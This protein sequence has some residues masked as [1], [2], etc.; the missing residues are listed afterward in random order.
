MTVD[1][2]EVVSLLRKG[3]K[4]GVMIYL[5]HGGDPN[6]R[7]HLGWTL[8]HLACVEVSDRS[9]SV[10]FSCTVN[11]CTTDMCTPLHRASAQGYSAVV[12]LLLKK[13][14]YV[15]AQDKAGNTPLHEAARGL[16]TAVVK[17]LIEKKADVTKTNH[18]NQVFLQLVGQQVMPV[19]ESGDCDTLVQ[20]LDWG[21]S[22]DIKGN[23]HWSALHHASARG[24]LNIVSILL[25]RGANVNA[26]D[27]N[28]TTPLHTAAFHGHLRIAELLID[29]G[30]NLNASDQRGNTPLHSAIEGCHPGVINLMLDRGCDT[31]IPNKEGQIFTHLVNEFLVTAVHAVNVGHVASLLKG[32]AD[33]DSRDSFGFPVLCHAAF[34][35]DVL[36]AD[37][38]LEAGANPNLADAGGKTPLHHAAYW[39]HLFVP[40]PYGKGRLLN[41]QDKNGCT[42]LHEA[43]REG[44]EDAITILTGRGAKLDATD[45]EGNTPLHAAARWGQTTAVELLI[46]KGASDVIKNKSGLLYSDLALIRAVRTEERSQVMAGLAWGGDPNS[47]DARRQT[48]LHH[49]VYKGAQE[50]CVLLLECGADVNAVDAH[51]R[52]PLLLAAYRGNHQIMQ[53]LL[54][55]GSDINAQDWTGQTPLHWA[56]SEGSVDTVHLLLER[57]AVTSV[58]NKDGLLYTDLLLKHLYLAVRHNDADKVVGLVRAGADQFAEVEGTGLNPREE[59]KRQGLYDILRQMAA[60]A[61]K[62]PQHEDD[63][64]LALEDVYRLFEDGYI[65]EDADRS[66]SACGRSE[67]EEDEEEDQEEDEDAYWKM[68][69]AY[70]VLTVEEAFKDEDDWLEA[71][72]EKPK[73]ISAKELFEEDQAAFWETWEEKPKVIS[74]KE[75]FKEDTNWWEDDD[76][77]NHDRRGEDEDKP[78]YISAKEFFRDDECWWRDALE[79]LQESQV[80]D[81]ELFAGGEEKKPKIMT[82]KDFFKDEEKPW[83]ETEEEEHKKVISAKEFFK[84]DEKPWWET[85]EFIQQEKPSGFL[86]GLKKSS[87]F[88]HFSNSHFVGSE[89]ESEILEGREEEEQEEEKED[90]YSASESSDDETELSSRTDDFEDANDSLLS[91]SST[92]YSASEG[93]RLPASVVFRDTPWW[94]TDDQQDENSPKASESNA[95]D[96]SQEKLWLD[97][98]S[99]AS[100]ATETLDMDTSEI[101]EVATAT[102]FYRRASESSQLEVVSSICVE[103]KRSDVDRMRIEIDTDQ[104]TIATDRE[105]ESEKRENDEDSN[106]EEEEEEK[107][108]TDEKENDRKKNVSYEEDDKGIVEDYNSE[109]EALKSEDEIED[110]SDEELVEEDENEYDSDEEGN[111]RNPS[112]TMNSAV[113][114][115][116]PDIKRD[117][118]SAVQENIRKNITPLVEIEMYDKDNDTLNSRPGD[119]KEKNEESVGI[120]SPTFD[121]LA[122]SVSKADSLEKDGTNLDVGTTNTDSLLDRNQLSVDAYYMEG[123]LQ[124]S[125]S[126]TSGYESSLSLSE[127]RTSHLTATCNVRV[128]SECGESSSEKQSEIESNENSKQEMITVE[129]VSPEGKDRYEPVTEVRT[130]TAENDRTHVDDVDEPRNVLPEREDTCNPVTKTMTE[131]GKD[132]AICVD[133]LQHVLPETED[134]YEPMTEVRNKAVEDDATRVN[135]ADNPDNIAEINEEDAEEINRTQ[136]K[137]EDV[138]RVVIQMKLCTDDMMKN[139]NEVKEENEPKTYNKVSEGERKDSEMEN[140]IHKNDTYVKPVKLQP[141]V[142]VTLTQ[143]YTASVKESL[144][145]KI[146]VNKMDACLAKVDAS[147]AWVDARL[148]KDSSSRMQQGENKKAEDVRTYAA[149]LAQGARTTPKYCGAAKTTKPHG[150]S[151]DSA[152]RAKTKSEDKDSVFLMKVH[153]HVPE[154]SSEVWPAEEGA[155][156]SQDG[157][158]LHNIAPANGKLTGGTFLGVVNNGSSD[159]K[160]SSKYISRLSE[161]IDLEDKDLNTCSIKPTEQILTAKPNIETESVAEERSIK[162]SDVTTSKEIAEDIQPKTKE[163]YTHSRKEIYSRRVLEEKTGNGNIKTL[164]RGDVNDD[165]CKLQDTLLNKVGPSNNRNEDMCSTHVDVTSQQDQRSK[166]NEDTCGT[167]VT[168]SQDHLSKEN[169]DTSGTQVDTASQQDQHSIENVDVCSTHIDTTSQQYQRSRENEDTCGTHVTTSQRN[170]CNKENEDTVSTNV[171]TASQDQNSSNMPVNSA[172]QEDHSL[173][174]ERESNHRVNDNGKTD[175]NLTNEKEKELSRESSVERSSAPSAS[176]AKLLS[177]QKTLWRC[178]T[179]EAMSLSDY[180]NLAFLISKSASSPACWPTMTTHK[181]SLSIESLD[182]ATDEVSSKATTGQ[183]HHLLEETLFNSTAGKKREPSEETS[184]KSTTGQKLGSPEDTSS[185]GGTRHKHGPSEEP[186]SRSTQQYAGHSVETSVKGAGGQNYDSTSEEPWNQFSKSN[187]MK[188]TRPDLMN[189]SSSRCHI[190]GYANERKDYVEEVSSS[191]CRVHKASTNSHD[192]GES[193]TETSSYRDNIINEIPQTSVACEA[194]SMSPPA[195]VETQACPNHSETSTAQHPF[196]VPPRRRERKLQYQTVDDKD[197]GHRPDSKSNELKSPTNTALLYDS[198]EKEAGKIAAASQVAPEARHVSAI[199]SKEFKREKDKTKEVSIEWSGFFSLTSAILLLQNLAFIYFILIPLIKLI[200]SF[201]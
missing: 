66:S 121:L 171:D 196:L 142:G 123:N 128:D 108:A 195:P 69:N 132:D 111:E 82:A 86:S 77:E 42:P 156:A 97:D 172:S 99:E 49:A 151:E 112:G 119:G 134:G 57:G 93:E 120:L 106:G 163:R 192:L 104:D 169:E 127:S 114:A 4:I 139:V 113:S 17:M 85:E 194:S 164:K 162:E 197:D 29:A 129:N 32:H 180:D 28:R 41:A 92:M 145:D 21:L 80:S 79:D 12:E 181:L 35:G 53:L 159:S 54:D 8:L 84:D 165:M 1:T 141:S 71:W 2:S 52:T 34:K 198:D 124:K 150:R 45:E 188:E 91:D 87:D 36:I 102:E 166:E 51:G 72:M 76:E 15:N 95:M 11:S 157:T 168:A 190:D 78:K 160:K 24:H 191:R 135:K 18:K 98:L 90:K 199:T 73:V 201:L 158:S 101:S 75:L 74:A 58:R 152:V 177:S 116:L 25:E 16:H 140:R 107:E 178:S 63:K 126:Q 167:H 47:R 65:T 131:A 48:L 187:T 70:E 30:A 23:L 38:L 117:G 39:G 109:S 56:A 200:A 155:A 43:A 6:A 64:I 14:A 186:S 96:A 103:S 68:S 59:A 7:N 89:E 130:D 144:G 184:A 33:P 148:T 136:V 94:E 146:A 153:V 13:N 125:D 182:K 170:E 185:K 40:R 176:E 137:P 26:E 183:K 189:T 138:K 174:D 143:S 62:E 179:Y 133:K 147:L 61:K 27:S 22:P 44:V 105:S 5:R 67:T 149:V 173:A 115:E 161:G 193:Q 9:S 19:V 175:A 83:W 55:E 3:D 122:D 20:W 118:N 81:E 46:E 110:I 100:E 37:A 154:E 10:L 88:A 50:I 31:S 60:L